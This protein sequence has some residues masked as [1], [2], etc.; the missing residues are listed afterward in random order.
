VSRAQWVGGVIFVVG[1]LAACSQATAPAAPSGPADK[2]AEI[3]ARGTLVIATD[4]AYPPLSVLKEGSERAAMT[5]CE[6]TELTASELTGFDIDTAVELARRLE[7]EPCFVTPQ[8]TQITAGSW[9]DRWDISVGSMTITRERLATLYFAQPYYASPTLFYIHQDNNTVKAPSDL[10][11]KRIGVCAGCT[12][13]RYLEGT[14]D[15]PGPTIEFMVK[16]AEIVAYDNEEPALQDLAQGDGIKLDAVMAELPVGHGAIKRGLPLKAVEKPA[17]F[18]FA[19]VVVDK[20]HSKDPIPLVK[21]LT[22][23]VQQMH[24]DGTLSKLSQQYQGID[25]TKE[26]ASFDLQAMKQFP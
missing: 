17:F 14:L 11:G 1:L 23:L 8:W 16:D 13:E 21:R 10:S 20:Q 2:L 3:Q 24:A 6:P 9:G 18:S 19:A 26:A 7:L 22:E 12:F 25:L 15:L 4:P 5:K